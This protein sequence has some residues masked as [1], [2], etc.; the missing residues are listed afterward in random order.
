MN[1]IV[2]ITRES[3]ICKTLSCLPEKFVVDFA[4]GIDVINDHLRVQRTRTSFGAR[5]VDG[6]TG[7]G[8]RRQIEI[9]ASLADGVESSLNWLQE[10]SQSLARSNFAIIQV[11]DRVAMIQESLITLANY[12]A[13]TRLQIESLSTALDRRCEQIE[14]EIARVDLVQRA[15]IHIDQI[16]SRWEAGRF[17]DF[18]LAG[19]CY[20]AFEE[21]RWGA[22]GDLCRKGSADERASHLEI[23]SNRAIVLL[24]DDMNEF[25]NARVNVK[26][27]LMPSQ[28]V[29]AD[30]HDALAYIGD[31]ASADHAPFV[32]A[33]LHDADELPLSVPRICS[34]TRLT[35]ALAEEVF[36]GPQ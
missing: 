12:S 36:G 4:N 7:K 28:H 5:L 31:W 21:L 35:E 14:N 23:A 15:T 22:F 2:P 24:A 30:A 16:F 26:Q 32:H 33:V 11:K 18:S 17:A 6:F 25:P 8:S 27:W 1:A 29:N 34:A 13:D 20:A 10:L 9:N 19:R 3:E